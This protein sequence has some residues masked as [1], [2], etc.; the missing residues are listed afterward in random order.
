MNFASTIK[1]S[2]SILAV[3]VLMLGMFAGAGVDSAQA[4]SNGPSFNSGTHSLFGQAT[5]EKDFLRLGVNGEKGNTL[6]VCRDGTEVKVWFYVH[7]HAPSD[8]NG[9][10]LDGSAVATNTTV[11]LKAATGKYAN[12]HRL[13]GYIDS[14][15]TSPINNSVTIQCGS[16]KIALEYSDIDV[17]RLKD[18]SS[19]SPGPDKAA[20]GKYSLWSNPL[21]SNAQIGFRGGKMPGCW[22]YR[23][24]MVFKFKVR[25]SSPTTVNPGPTNP[26]PTNPNPGPTN[27]GN[28]NTHST[29]TNTVNQNTHS[30]NTNAVNGGDSNS[31]AHNTNTNTNEVNNNNVN[32]NN[33]NNVN[34]VNVNVTVNTSSD[35]SSG[36][37]SKGSSGS[38]RGGKGSQA[39]PKNLP[40]T[41]VS[42][43]FAFL[44]VAGAATMAHRSLKLRLAR[45]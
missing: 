24:V 29:N 6:T 2:F 7:N 13:H 23:M 40:N 35:D 42:L 11:R 41:G 31:N 9:T 16:K 44:A 22:H 25:V 39:K 10:D 45:R 26:G 18:T 36:N 37:D 3:A 12:G 34:N 27:P 20:W 17:S 38:T 33:N 28:Q 32:H 5:S 1:R 8:L 19:T 30:T 21:N 14:D 43:T 4:I 15:Q